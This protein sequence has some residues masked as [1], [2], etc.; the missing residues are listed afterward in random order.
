MAKVTLKGYFEPTPVNIRKAAD[1]M[2]AGALYLQADPSLLG[3]DWSRYIMLAVG[4]LKI[5]SNFFTN[6]PSDETTS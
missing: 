4:L 3:S 2:L 1:A 5:A 6:S